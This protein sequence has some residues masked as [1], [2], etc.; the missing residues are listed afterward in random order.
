MRRT[1]VALTCT[2]TA[3]VLLAPAASA[4]KPFQIRIEEPAS[5]VLPGSDFCGFDVQVDAEQ[6][7][8][9]IIFSG[10]RGTWIGG[11]TAGKIKIVLT[12]LETDESIALNI[13]GPGFLD[14]DGNLV[15]GTGPWVIFIEGHIQYLV[16][17]ITFVPDPFGVRASEVRGRVVELCDVLA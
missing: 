8:K 10:D 11:L 13:S 3:L 14:V 16:G 12:N 7:F 4:V 9:V 5:F 1:F 17:H 6:K 2:V 15:Q